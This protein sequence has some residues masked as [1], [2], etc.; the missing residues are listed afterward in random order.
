M[1]Q[2]QTFRVPHSAT[3]SLPTSKSLP[4]FGSTITRGA[5]DPCFPLRGEYNL[6]SLLLL[7]LCYRKNCII[8]FKTDSCAI[9]PQKIR[10]HDH[11][12]LLW[13]DWMSG[14]CSSRDYFLCNHGKIKKLYVYHQDNSRA[15]LLQLC[16]DVQKWAA[17]N[18]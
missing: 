1:Q 7:C 2:Q 8:Q 5:N 3:P 12:E 4:L 14:K 9:L 10:R 18:R 17:R 11:I 16:L 15:L 13:L 6:C